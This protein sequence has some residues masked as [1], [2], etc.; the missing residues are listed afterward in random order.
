MFDPACPCGPLPVALSQVSGCTLSSKP[1]P[2]PKSRPGP[3]MLRKPRRAGLDTFL[4]QRAFVLGQRPKH[5][6]QARPLWCR[7]LPLL[8]QGA[9]GYA[10][11]LQ[12]CNSVPQGDRTCYALLSTA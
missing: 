2:T 10:P 12:G 11:R 5:A 7:G 6:Q 3:G 4:G 9:K 8:G 1:L